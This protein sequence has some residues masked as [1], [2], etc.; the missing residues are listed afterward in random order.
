M[1]WFSLLVPTWSLNL[2]CI[3]LTHRGFGIFTVRGTCAAPLHGQGRV[4]S[5]ARG[6]DPMPGKLASSLPGGIVVRNK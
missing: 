4:L 6:M 3:C 5:L 2:V 1:V